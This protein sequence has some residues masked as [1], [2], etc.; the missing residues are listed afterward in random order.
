MYNHHGTESKKQPYFDTR[1]VRNSL[2]PVLIASILLAYLLII[3]SPVDKKALVIDIIKPTSAA[4]ATALSLVVVYRQKTDGIIGKAFTFLAAGLTLFLIGELISSYNDIALGIENSLPSIAYIFWTMAYGPIFYFV[5]KMY[6]FLGAS[7]SKTHQ[8][9]ICIVGAVFLTYFIIL[10]SHNAEFSTQRGIASF[11]ISIAYPVLDV[12]LIVPSAL[13]LLNPVKGSL[14]AIP[15]IFLA[16]LI[17]GI[18]D[19]I[20][21]YTYNAQA[22]EDL[23][24]ISKL[25]FITSYVITDFLIQRLTSEKRS[26]S[27]TS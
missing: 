27:R 5:F 24:W 10:T 23:N 22:I 12:I 15:W 14:T 13:I 26:Q 16:V 8:I 4:I 19:S 9:L 7:H 1:S 6:Y 17:L 11:L 3:L 18:G 20:F 25:F 21:A 2:I